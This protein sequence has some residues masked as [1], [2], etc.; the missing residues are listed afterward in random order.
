MGLMV[1]V[2]EMT[3]ES[4]VGTDGIMSVAGAPGVAVQ[5]S[6]ADFAVSGD[7]GEFRGKDGKQLSMG[8][9]EVKKAGQLSSTLSDEMFLG[10][11]Y[12]SLSSAKGKIQVQI[13]GFSR[14]NEPE[15]QYGSIVN[16]MTHAGTIVL[17]GAMIS[18]D[19]QVGDLLESAGVGATVQEPAGLMR[20]LLSDDSLEIEGV[21]NA[22]N[23]EGPVTNVGEM[24]DT[25]SLPTLIV[26]GTC[27]MGV[28]I[29]DFGQDSGGAAK[30]LYRDA[31]RDIL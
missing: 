9:V 20:R 8:S 23:I 25:D 15:S 29:L 4:K 19:N 22:N 16:L 18:V 10:L 30:P 26:A 11:K 13:F 5:T 17:D 27:S 28:T 2:V 3:K 21:F 6:S 31:L 7:S 1:V 12:F 14:I 24:V